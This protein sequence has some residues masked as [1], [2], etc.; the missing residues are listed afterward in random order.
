MERVFFCDGMMQ[1]TAG[2]R[3]QGAFFLY[4]TIATA[5]SAFQ[6]GTC[7]FLNLFKRGNPQTTKIMKFLRMAI[8][9]APGEGPMELSGSVRLL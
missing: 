1:R 6:W 8:L 7:V 4:I 2:K 9:I 3:R 5:Y